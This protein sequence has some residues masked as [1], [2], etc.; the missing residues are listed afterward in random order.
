[1]RALVVEHPQRV[2]LGSPARLLVQRKAEQELLQQLSILRP[3]RV[4]AQRGDLEPEPGQ[5]EVPEARVGDGDD[6]GV[7]RRVVDTDG[8]D[9]DLLE[10]AVAAGLGPLVAEERAGIGDLHRQGPAVEPVF[11]HRTHDARGPLGPEGDAAITLVGEGVHLLADHVGRFADAPREQGGVLE[12][13]QFD[14]PV[15]GGPRRG[16]EAVAHG[17][18][19]GRIRG[20]VVRHALRGGEGPVVLAHRCPRG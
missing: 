8:L 14:V 12:D 20:K 2:D 4:V 3:A 9:P 17:H 1:M 19:G 6:L 10:L 11:D 7:E 13:G 18:E 16:G 15:A 5:S